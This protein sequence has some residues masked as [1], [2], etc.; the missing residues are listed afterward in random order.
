LII[1]GC[2]LLTFIRV[3]RSIPFLVLPKCPAFSHTCDT[4]CDVTTAALSLPL[5]LFLQPISGSVFTLPWRVQLPQAIQSQG[6]AQASSFL[7]LLS[8]AVTSACNGGVGLGN[9][10]GSCPSTDTL[11]VVAEPRMAYGAAASPSAGSASSAGGQGAAAGASFCRCL[12]SSPHG[13]CPSFPKSVLL[14]A[15]PNV[16]LCAGANVPCINASSSSLT[17]SAISRAGVTAGVSIAGAFVVVAA[18]IGAAIVA[19]R[20]RRRVTDASPDARKSKSLAALSE[21][22]SSGASR[23]TLASQRPSSVPRLISTRR[24]WPTPVASVA[25]ASVAAPGVTGQRRASGFGPQAAHGPSNAPLSTQQPQQQ[26][27]QQQQQGALGA[28]FAE[29]PS[30][31][32]SVDTERLGTSSSSQRPGS[33]MLQTGGPVQPRESVR[34]GLGPAVPAATTLRRP[35]PGDPQPL[36]TAT[37]AAATP[38]TRGGAV[39]AGAAPAQAGHRRHSDPGT[40]P[41]RS[42]AV[43][44]F[45]IAGTAEFFSRPSSRSHA[46]G[47]LSTPPS[48]GSDGVP[49]LLL[50]N[51]QGNSAGQQRGPA[52]SGRSSSL[53]SSRGL[54]TAATMHSSRP[55]AAAASSRSPAEAAGRMYRSASVTSQAAPQPYGVAA[56]TG[57]GGSSV[58]STA[59]MAGRTV[60][61]RSAVPFAQPAAQH[62]FA[63]LESPALPGRVPQPFTGIR[64]TDSRGSCATAT[65]AADARTGMSLALTGV[66]GSAA[67]PEDAAQMARMISGRSRPSG[68]K[69]EAGATGPQ[70]SAVQ[71]AG[72][73]APPL[74]AVEAIGPTRS[75]STSAAPLPSAAVAA[76]TSVSVGPASDAVHLRSTGSGSS[77]GTAVVVLVTGRNGGSGAQLPAAAVAVPVAA[78][79]GGAGAA[80]AGG[81]RQRSRPRSAS[82]P[83]VD[84]KPCITIFE[85][86]KAPDVVRR[87]DSS[88]ATAYAVGGAPGDAGGDMPVSLTFAA[89]DGSSKAGAP[90]GAAASETL[91]RP[92][93]SVARPRDAVEEDAE[94]AEDPLYRTLRFG[95]DATGNRSMLEG[96]SKLL[97]AAVTGHSAQSGPARH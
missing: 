38:A 10:A 41:P 52:D 90:A 48:V 8:S 47:Q 13:F 5:S 63:D 37:H 59:R 88:A 34:S 61:A 36:A 65:S 84:P 75:R 17:A 91:R 42:G 60:A 20:R 64:E 97:A 83:A 19:A 62:G 79:E 81:L 54:A 67:A 30:P 1:S 57:R 56:A 51:L 44:P 23:L 87:V 85:K 89:A 82:E 32:S 3:T 31:L 15:W 25:S 77:Q 12:L 49:T 18:G 6:S 73:A 4:A 21:D 95:R 53:A 58:L 39:S 43:S 28:A 68:G 16:L 14:C 2:A 96:V 22:A 50:G 26:Q 11:A 29:P 66:A 40:P 78:D 86:K 27:Q 71:Q 35:S 46:R 55:S 93:M 9:A 92:A 80:G 72:R 76:G 74:M 33:A 45:G 94:D 69:R 24:V 7:A 70:R